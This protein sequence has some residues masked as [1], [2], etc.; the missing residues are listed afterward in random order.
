MYD[1]HFLPE[2]CLGAYDLILVLI[3]IFLLFPPEVLVQH[4]CG[5]AVIVQDFSLHVPY[6][7]LVDQV[8][9]VG[10]MYGLRGGRAADLILI[11]DLLD[12]F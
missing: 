11:I 3:I 9:A 5:V 1:E 8:L 4:L 2:I 7:P 10:A 12:S 6:I